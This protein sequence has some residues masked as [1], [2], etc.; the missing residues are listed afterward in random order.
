MLFNILVPLADDHIVFNVF[1][2][3][4]F[5][6]GGAT[7]TAL[8]ISFMLGPRIIAWLK[9]RQREGQPIRDD[10]PEGHLLTKKG[11]PTMGGVLILLAII[12]ST[13]LWADLTNGFVWVILFVTTGFGLIGFRRRLSE[14]DQAPQRQRAQEPLQVPRPDPDRR[15]SRRSG[16][17]YIEPR[18][19]CKP[20][21]DAG[22]Q[23]TC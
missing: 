10:G 9:S 22:V 5:R 1:R 15:C 3:L 20:T 21:G 14:A 16:S 17:S 11:T 13:L 23:G 4:T 2:Y 8:L 19:D 6:S 12:I 7:I 18:A